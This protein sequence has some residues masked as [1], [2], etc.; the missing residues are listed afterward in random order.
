M[1]CRVDFLSSSRP[2]V[3]VNAR[4]RESGAHAGP[5][6]DSSPDVSWQGGSEPSVGASQTALR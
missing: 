5:P 6:S 4:R 3:L 2:R 1:T